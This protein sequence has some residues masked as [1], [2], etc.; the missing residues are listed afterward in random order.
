MA[1]G[2]DALLAGSVKRFYAPIKPIPL[3]IVGHVAGCRKHQPTPIKMES[4]LDLRL[5]TCWNGA[6]R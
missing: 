5:Y 2:R 4:L 1:G 3:S 6:S